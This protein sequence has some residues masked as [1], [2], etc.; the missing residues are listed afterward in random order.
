MNALCKFRKRVLELRQNHKLGNLGCVWNTIINPK[1]HSNTKEGR[2]PAKASKAPGPIVVQSNIG[3]GR[4]GTFI[5]LDMCMEA[6][7]KTN[8]HN[9]ALKLITGL[10]ADR[11]QAVRKENQ[12]IAVANKVLQEAMIKDM[13]L[14]VENLDPF[15]NIDNIPENDNIAEGEEKKADVH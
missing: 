3:T 12:Y 8:D 15:K 13:D 5:L 14:Q 7:D 6:L 9:A 10:Q 1:W 4:S 2:T 11:A